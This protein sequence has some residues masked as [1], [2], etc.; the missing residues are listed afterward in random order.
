[1][2]YLRTQGLAAPDSVI[3][4]HG[5][6]DHAGGLTGLRSA[7]PDVPVYTGV[8]DRVLVAI[9]CWRSQHWD[10]EGVHFEMLYPE[11]GNLLSRVVPHW[12]PQPLGFPQ[13]GGV[14]T[15]SAAGDIGGYGEGRRALHAV[16]RRFQTDVIHALAARC[17]ASLDS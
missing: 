9:P 10:W 4:S 15:L 6:N 3:V 8:M 2:P 16:P 12:L 11:S 17:L 5:D 14:G 7:Y 1:M 13:I